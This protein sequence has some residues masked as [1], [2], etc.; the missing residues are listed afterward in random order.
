MIFGIIFSFD[1]GIKNNYSSFYKNA[2]NIM[3]KFDI[4]KLRRDELKEIYQENKD[5][6]EDTKP[7]IIDENKTNK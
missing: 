6:A 1:T 7:A 5:K 4:G 3:F 2:S